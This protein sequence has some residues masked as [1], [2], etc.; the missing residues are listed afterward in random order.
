MGV[1]KEIK[2]CK[3]GKSL[4]TI[5]NGEIVFKGVN[6]DWVRV[7]QISKSEKTTKYKCRGCYSVNSIGDDNKPKIDEKAIAKDLLYNYKRK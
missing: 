5:E 3:C 7:T 4:A 6:V 1:N 2:C